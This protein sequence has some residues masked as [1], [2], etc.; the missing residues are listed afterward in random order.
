ML[1]ERC[2]A[3]AET[4]VC[5]HRLSCYQHKHS[6]M[7]AAGGLSQTQHSTPWSGFPSAPPSPTRFQG[8]PAVLRL[9]APL[10]HPSQVGPSPKPWADY[11]GRRNGR[12]G[13]V[14]AVGRDRLGMPM[15]LLPPSPEKMQVAHSAAVLVQHHQPWGGTA[16]GGWTP[17]WGFGSL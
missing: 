9:V 14:S 15:A 11:G 8:F 12:M 7:R 1:C 16:G 17:H 6:T 4:P 2:S 10:L 13:A 3:V 5:Y